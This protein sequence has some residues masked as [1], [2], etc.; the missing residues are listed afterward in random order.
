MFFLVCKK[1]NSLEVDHV[2]LMRKEACN[3]ALRENQ[4]IFHVLRLPTGPVY[5]G[6]DL[7]VLARSI[8][9]PV[10]SEIARQHAP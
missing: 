8:S 3:A 9:K 4:R 5:P 2:V 1:I 10:N 7:W 6:C